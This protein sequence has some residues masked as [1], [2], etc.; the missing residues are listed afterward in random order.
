MSYAKDTLLSA[1]FECEATAWDLNIQEPS[2]YLRGHRYPLHDAKLMVPNNH[3][4]DNLRAL[5]LDDS[6]EFRL[7]N[8][9]VREKGSGAQLAETLQIF[10]QSVE[11][12][13]TA[14]KLKFIATPYNVRL[15]RDE[16][17]NIVSASSR[18]VH[19]IP[20]KVSVDF[21]PPVC[22]GYSDP[23]TCI[24]TAVGKS[25][26]KYDVSSGSYHSTIGNICTGDITYFL[27]DGEQCRRI[28]VGTAKGFLYLL[29]FATGQVIGRVQ[30]H[31]K[32]ILCLCTVNKRKEIPNDND[33]MVYSGSLDGNIRQMK[34]VGGT[35]EITHTIE[36]AMGSHRKIVKLEAFRECNALICVALKR[37]AIFS[38][39]SMK[40]NFLFTE[41]HEITDLEF[42][43]GGQG[44]SHKKFAK[45]YLEAV[46]ME[47]EKIVTMVMSTTEE[48]KV[49]AIDLTKY[50]T[51]LT[52]TLGHSTLMHFCSI[53]KLSYP[54]AISVNYSR[55]KNQAPTLCLIAASEEGFV[56]VWDVKNIRSESLQCFYDNVPDF[57]AHI[58]YKVKH[59]TAK[60]ASSSSA[61]M[62]A[63]MLFKRGAKEVRPFSLK[64]RGNTKSSATNAKEFVSLSEISKSFDDKDDAAAAPKWNVNTKRGDN[65]KVS[66]IHDN[67][68]DTLSQVSLTSLEAHSHINIDC[69]SPVKTTSS[70]FCDTDKFSSDEEDEN[71]KFKMSELTGNAK[72][73]SYV[74]SYHSFKAHSDI[75]HNLVPLTEHC[76]LASSSQDGFHRVW[77]LLGDCLGEMP[78][79]NIT[80]KMQND[81]T[82]CKY[83]WRF[84]AEKIPVTKAH[85]SISQQLCKDIK[86]GVYGDKNVVERR[87]AID[88]GLAA[89]KSRTLTVK[90]VTPDD[91][92]RKNILSSLK[93]EA[94]LSPLSKG[95][96][97]SKGILKTIAKASEGE[98]NENHESECDAS[99]SN[100]CHSDME[101]TVSEPIHANTN[102]KESKLEMKSE[103]GSSSNV[104]RSKMDSSM[105]QRVS[106][107]EDMWSP[108]K[109]VLSNCSVAFSES[110][111]SAASSEGVYNKVCHL[112]TFHRWSLIC[113]SCGASLHYTGGIS[114]SSPS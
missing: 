91:I 114:H 65:Y 13:K 1:G 87:K 78:L 63:A 11:S 85:V 75:I 50:T 76:C 99:S 95:S 5:T 105:K 103:I 6:G 57:L 106:R 51:V 25:L 28:Y 94:E 39:S 71:N 53:C 52:H 20:S 48:I 31:S 41:T 104:Q 10:K 110:S 23:H 21:F 102:L 45:N 92:K 61:I 30:A 43:G 109:K 82:R 47:S 97:D 107:P 22:M 80:E 100:S 69:N 44:A 74:S 2:F 37:W 19:F 26:V 56:T 18:L 101:S 8:I 81:P 89:N 88:A 3:Q 62:K 79:P 108:V 35:L 67:G 38:L 77:N 9:F 112:R 34:E 49:Y 40:R 83:S 46:R 7:W 96:F 42:L 59:T 58:V 27:L 90:D 60:V 12:E 70:S 54:K 33:T 16:Y 72:N 84:I 111:I 32:D 93:Y 36:N 64:K 73:A 17:S 15:S 113:K 68:D 55:V 14:C 98:S 4:D 86:E 29:N 66:S 24:I